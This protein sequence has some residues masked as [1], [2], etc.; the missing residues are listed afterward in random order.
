MVQYHKRSKSKSSGSG[1]R[2]RSAADKRKAHWGGFFAHAKLGAQHVVNAFRTR[3]GQ[4][5]AAVHHALYANV[6]DGKN[7]QK[8]KILTVKDSPDNRHFARENVV[9]RGALV[10]TE[11][12][13][14]K[15][16][17]RPGQHGVVNAV[18]QGKPKA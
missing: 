9:T 17:S 13:L 16:T 10:E 11:L 8:T 18:L 2:R 1:G 6:S 14:A 3:G 15:V 12:G 5:K 7:V 4:K